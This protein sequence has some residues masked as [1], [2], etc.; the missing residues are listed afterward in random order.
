M[1]HMITLMYVLCVVPNIFCG[2][3]VLCMYVWG[4]GGGCLQHTVQR[5]LTE[6]MNVAF[7]DGQMNLQRNVNPA[8]A[9]VVCCS[10]LD[11]AAVLEAYV[12]GYTIYKRL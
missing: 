10:L 5:N 2:H 8:S 6:M 12:A 9:P 11:C 4:G 7:E 3:I 1:F